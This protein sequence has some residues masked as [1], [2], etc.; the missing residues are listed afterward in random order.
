VPG[1]RC[2]IP[3]WEGGGRSRP[4]GG[5]ACCTSGLCGERGPATSHTRQGAGRQAGSA[6]GTW[7]AARRTEHQGVRLLRPC[8]WAGWRCELSGRGAACCRQA[9]VLGW[10]CLAQRRSLARALCTAVLC[11]L[12]RAPRGLAERARGQPRGARS[13]P[14]G[15]LRGGGA[16]AW[17]SNEI[18]SCAGDVRARAGAQKR[19]LCAFLARLSL[20]PVWWRQC[21]PRTLGVWVGAA[22]RAGAR[23]AVGAQRRRTAPAIGAAQRAGDESVRGARART[24]RATD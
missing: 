8:V 14:A 1:G 16:S 23:C 24:R 20:G 22:P 7:R 21:A 10:L 6:S 13:M 18:R 15:C 3:Q 12:A 4:R 5:G 17:T 2:A 11:T 19:S 9:C